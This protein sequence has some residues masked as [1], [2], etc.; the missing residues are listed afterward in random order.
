MTEQ[1]NDLLVFS[2]ELGEV[3]IELLQLA[4][5]ISKG[6]RFGV[7]EKRDF[8]ASNRERITAEWND[9]LGSVERLRA[10]GINLDTDVKAV[11]A[12]MAKIE[13]YA[14]YSRELGQI[15]K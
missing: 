7:D 4:N 6:I 2:E 14:G 13:K 11:M 10:R 1:Q 12:K 5:L 3:A 15:T 9:L 8:P